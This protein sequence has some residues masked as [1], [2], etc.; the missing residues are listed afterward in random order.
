MPRPNRL[1]PP[2]PSTRAIHFRGD[3]AKPDPAGFG[4]ARG[5]VRREG[6]GQGACSYG[7]IWRKT[8]EKK[9]IVRKCLLNMSFVPISTGDFTVRLLGWGIK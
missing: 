7:R 2:P 5:D 8:S 3:A 6:G 9:H 1:G 4:G